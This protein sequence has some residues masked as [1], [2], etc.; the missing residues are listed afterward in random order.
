[1]VR[2]QSEVLQARNIRH[3]NGNVSRQDIPSEI[4]EFKAREPADVSR[5]SSRKHVVGEVERLETGDRTGRDRSGQVVIAEVEVLNKI[6][7]STEH[8]TRDL[9]S[10]LIAGEI[11]GLDTRQSEYRRR[12]FARY[13]LAG[14]LD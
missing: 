12:D 8:V 5:D 4:E 13:V 11:N 6:E 14:E 10:Q 9:A 1:M 3:R 2:S 7:S